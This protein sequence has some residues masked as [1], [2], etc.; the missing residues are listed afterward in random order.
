MIKIAGISKNS[1]L[2]IS[3]KLLILGCSAT[4][5]QLGTFVAAG[6]D[7]DQSSEPWTS[8]RRLACCKGD[9]CL[10]C[11]ELSYETF[12]TRIKI[13]I[14]NDDP[15]LIEIETDS[16]QKKNRNQIFPNRNRNSAHPYNGC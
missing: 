9:G 10:G 5:D 1:S 6:I 3:R 11:A 13:E 2:R 14:F 8:S 16:F 7:L 12:E 15:F 4:I